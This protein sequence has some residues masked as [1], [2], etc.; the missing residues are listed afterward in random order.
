MFVV[1]CIR[2]TLSLWWRSWYNS[3]C[4]D[5]NARWQRLIRRRRPD[6]VVRPVGNRF[7]RN[8]ISTAA[9]ATSVRPCIVDKHSPPVTAAVMTHDGVTVSVTPL[10]PR[11]PYPTSTYMSPPVGIY[12]LKYYIIIIS[13]IF[14]R[15]IFDSAGVKYL[16]RTVIVVIVI[17]ALRRL[18]LRVCII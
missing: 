15:V 14:S 10:S 1:S 6:I 17:V 8:S 12:I 16:R 9:S 18:S 11:F 4:G 5:D 7:A 13:I 3:G 2:A